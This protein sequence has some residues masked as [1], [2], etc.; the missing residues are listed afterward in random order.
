M[1]DIYP[2]HLQN[3]PEFR[4]I[5]KATDRQIKK[6]ES[7]MEEMQD[8]LIISTAR[9]SGISDR[10]KILKIVPRDTDTL[11]ERRYKV[12]LRWYDTFPYTEN[13][14]FARLDRICGPD[15]YELAINKQN[16]EVKCLV[17]LTSKKMLSDIENLLDDILSLN[18]ALSVGLRYNQ[19]Y[20]F[21][22][23]TWQQFKS[24]TWDRLRNE[25][26]NI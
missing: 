23:A 21:E 26:I 15:Q 5:S 11:E 17:E 7:R 9:E 24:Y 18:V 12:L 14:L 3:M 20:K 22:R 6:I 13:D 10:E 25:V 8:N 19:W 1:Y 2:E 4:S 16:N